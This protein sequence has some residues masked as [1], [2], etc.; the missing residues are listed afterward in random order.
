MANES[1]FLIVLLLPKWKDSPCRTHSILSHPNTCTLVRLNPNQ[2]KFVPANKL[3]Y[4]NL[5]K[6]L[7]KAANR[8][9]YIVIVANTDGRKNYLHPNHLQHILIPD[10][11][12]ACQDAT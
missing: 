3:I 2:L 4:N 6:L 8:S 12:R 1:P 7:L 10:I 9:I 11:L 5:S